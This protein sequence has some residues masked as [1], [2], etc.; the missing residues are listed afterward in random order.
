[1]LAQYGEHYMAQKSLY[2]WVDR[3]KCGRKTLDEEGWSGQPSTSQTDDHHAEVD[4]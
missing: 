3:F 1:M 2:K 4:D